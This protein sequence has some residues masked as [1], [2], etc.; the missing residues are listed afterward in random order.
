MLDCPHQLA[1]VVQ[2]NCN[3]SDARYAGDYSLC[4]FLL[5]MREFYRWENAL[6]FSRALPKNELGNWLNARENLWGRVETEDFAHLPLM[7]ATLDPYDAKSANRELLPQG[8]VYSAGYGRFQKPLFFLGRLLRTE[9]RAGFTILVSS[10]EY[11]RELAAPPAML[12]GRTIFVRQESVRRYRWEKFEEWQWRKRDSAMARAFASYPFMNDAEAAL[13]Q[14]TENEMETMILH[15][16]GE[17]KA[18][19]L[20]GAQWQAM[21]MAVAR[22]KAEPYARAVRDLLADCLSTLPTL[23]ERG[24][25]PA[26]HF[27]FATFDAQRREL[28]P[29]ALRAY[30]YFLKH[31]ELKQLHQAADE[32]KA[33]WLAAARSL[34]AQHATESVAGGKM[35]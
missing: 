2:H 17:A 9:E 4:I 35:P 32:G 23:I 5:K 34:L 19:E 16:V 7:H 26:L 27:Y 24:N 10:C 21:V 12:Q 33:Y 25:L 1:N 11:A 28:F 20:L 29:Q 3:I 31:G 18:G 15:E 13:D 8:Y 14:M 30:A 6:P 22:T